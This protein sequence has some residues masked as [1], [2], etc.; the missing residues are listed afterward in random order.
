MNIEPHICL[1][2]RFFAAFGFGVKGAQKRQILA[3]QFVLL[4]SFSLP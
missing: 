1:N 3:K 2:Q 4:N